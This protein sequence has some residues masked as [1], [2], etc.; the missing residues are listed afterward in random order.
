MPATMTRRR[1]D[2]YATHLQAFGLVTSAIASP[3]PE[4]RQSDLPHDLFRAV[5]ANALLPPVRE[6]RGVTD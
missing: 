6:D 1:Y 4:S 5:S 3:V 2:L